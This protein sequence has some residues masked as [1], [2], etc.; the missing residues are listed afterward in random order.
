[1]EYAKLETAALAHLD[2]SYYYGAYCRRCKHAARL[3]LVKLRDHLG[4]GFPLRK[5]QRSLAMRALQI[6]TNC[7]YILG[8]R[9]K[10]RQSGAS[11][12]RCT[13]PVN[14]IGPARSFFLRSAGDGELER[15]NS[16]SSPIRVRGHTSSVLPTGLILDL[17]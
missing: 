13:S 16:F 3:S 11:L 15:D 12:P 4:D 7:H 10:N 1:M 9:P 17:V 8:A 2:D 6:S 14:V 5:V